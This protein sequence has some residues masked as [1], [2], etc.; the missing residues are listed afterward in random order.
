MKLIL[1]Q[2]G[3]PGFF[4]SKCNDFF[5]LNYN[6]SQLQVMLKND[7]VKTKYVLA[8]S[9]SFLGIDLNCVNRFKKAFKIMLVSNTCMQ[10][11]KKD[12]Y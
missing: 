10:F 12:I 8:F 9:N 6:I 2:K 3:S 7:T 1:S 11:S 5:E 4:K